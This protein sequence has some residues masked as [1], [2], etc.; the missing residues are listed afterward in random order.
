MS[1]TLCNNSSINLNFIIHVLN[2][3]NEEELF[4]KDGFLDRKEL[5]SNARNTW[6]TIIEDFQKSFRETG[7]DSFV[8]W[9]I[10]CIR[11]KDLFKVLFK[12]TEIGY[13][14]FLDIWDNYYK[15]WYEKYQ[16][17]IFQK[18]DEIIPDIYKL[19]YDKLAIKNINPTGNF[20][21]Q[22]ILGNIPNG[23]T[24]KGCI[25]TIEPIDNFSDKNKIIE[26]SER[27]YKLICATIK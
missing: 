4:S 12:D 6:N 9:D 3:Y 27:V 24:T 20:G 15:Q 7:N 22:I 25:F 11:K 23:F 13:N 18:T 26:V 5:E 21:I 8:Q 17:I 14:T 2:K 16:S 10:R 1:F 19:V